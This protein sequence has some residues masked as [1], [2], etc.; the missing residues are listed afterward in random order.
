MRVDKI[1][2]NMMVVTSIIILFCV[3]AGTF[4]KIPVLKIIGMR[5]GITAI[6][7]WLVTIFLFFCMMVI[8]EF[9]RKK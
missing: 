9:P 8:S 2:R 4:L 5:L 7:I 1:V 6:I 3:G